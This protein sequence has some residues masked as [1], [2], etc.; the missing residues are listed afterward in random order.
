MDLRI[1]LLKDDKLSYKDTVKNI[2][3]KDQILKFNLLDV[4]TTIDTANKIFIRENDEYIFYLDIIKKK[5]NIY[6]KQ[7]DIKFDINVDYSKLELKDE[8][9]IIEYMI[10]SEDSKINLIIDRK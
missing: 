8:Q 5:S 9:I 4:I 6:L 10:E 2:S 1:K 3:N 7:E